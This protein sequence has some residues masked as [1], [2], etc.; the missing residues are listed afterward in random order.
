MSATE[1]Q[2]AHRVPFLDVR[3][4]YLEI[5]NELD[6]AYREVMESG[7]FIMGPQL[8]AFEQDFARYCDAAYAVGVGTGLDALELVLR[9]WGVGPGDEVIVPAHTFVATWLA[10]SETGAT[11]IAV[12]VDPATFNIAAGLAENAITERTRAIIPVH[13]YGQTADM[14]RISELAARHDLL[15][16]EDS[17]QAHGATWASKTAGSMGDASA[18]SFYP[19]KNLGA[20]GDGGAITTNDADL[21]ARLRRLRN[22]GSSKKYHHE[23]VGVNS[24]LD[25]LQAALLRVRLR[26]LDVWNERRRVVASMYTEGLAGVDH[27]RTP[28]VPEEADPVWHLYAIVSEQRDALAGH[29]DRRGVD[30]AVHYPIPPHHQPAYADAYL[31]HQFPVADMIAE[32]QLSLPIGPHLAHDDTERVIAAVASFVP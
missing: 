26:H 2:A 12:D 32:Q 24:R 20:F 18:F 28:H 6:A 9:A 7:W 3:S 19:A 16:L 23:E 27:V 30:S 17:A 1:P 25:E 29:L 14:T 22:Y 10:V 13:L 21:A 11:P 31:Q 8:E 15:V 5:R 4:C